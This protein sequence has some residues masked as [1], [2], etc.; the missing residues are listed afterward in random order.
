MLLIVGE[1]IVAYQRDIGADGSHAD[2]PYTGPWPSGSPAIAAYVA[3]RLGVPTMFVGGVGRDSHGKVMADGLAA[4]NVVTDHLA[5]AADAPTATAY[6]TYRGEARDFDFRVA[7]TAA[8]LINE[9]DLGDLPER[10]DWVHMSGSALIFGEPLAATTLSALRRARAAGARISVDP[11]V[12]PE[13]LHRSARSALI[14]VL[15]LAHVLLPSEGEL[16][17]LGVDALSLVAAGATVCTTL[18]SGGATVT[19][20][21]GTTH[22]DALPVEPVDTDGAGD[23]FAA[24]FIAA[25]LAGQ[26]PVAAARAGARVA[27][28]A[29]QTEG[30][31]T[32]VPDAGLLAE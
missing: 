1:A 16:A 13:A 5:I 26:N 29:I 32:V 11:N 6:I 19:D 15:G 28:A 18:G 12:R 25:T 8:T 4:G 20:A 24:G 7:G 23:S 21:S 22:V 17:A 31:M 14:E 9:R 3:A 2:A 10:A 27:A 30:P